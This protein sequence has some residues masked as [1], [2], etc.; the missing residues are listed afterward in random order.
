[1][2]PFAAPFASA[3]SLARFCAIA[4]FLA[5]AACAAP[6]VPPP[7]PPPPPVPS[8][9]PATNPITSNQPEFLTLPNIAKDQSPLRVGIILPFTNT[10]PGVRALAGSMMK[11]AELALFDSGKSDIVLMSADEGNTPQDAAAAANKL[12]AEG[13]EVIVG[14]VFAQSVSAVAPLAHDR[15]VPVLAFSSDRTV[16]GNGAYLLSFQPENEVKR[17]IAYAAS[18]GHK[19]FAALIPQTTYGDHISKVFE[20]DV[21]AVGGTVA[22]VQHFQPT[23]DGVSAPS[24]TIAASNADAVLIAQGGVLLRAI[25]PTLASD[26]MTQDK[27][28]F[29]GTGVWDDESIAKE[30]MVDGGWFA[31]PAPNADTAFVAKYKNN[32]GDAPPRLAALAYDA[33]SL[34]ALLSG[35]TPYQRFTAQALT[36]PNGF[37]GVDGIFRFSPDGSAERGLAIL[38][39]TPDGFTVISPAPTTFQPQGS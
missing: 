19:H 18:Q 2:N 24:R 27:A 6:H 4:S 29:L 17:I 33:V 5:I 7:P 31:A 13:A 30:P 21:M 35:G 16:G 12:L 25:A 22:E 38:G 28:K 20:D 26:G 9:S 37:T 1:M 23:P 10:S 15:A 39:V 34:V 11:A 14:P 36:D 32:F 8:G 3:F